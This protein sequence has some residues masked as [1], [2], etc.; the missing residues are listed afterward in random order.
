MVLEYES[1]HLPQKSPSFGGFYIPAP[2][3]AYGSPKMTSIR[4]PA[5]N[6]HPMLNRRRRCDVNLW[7]VNRG[8]T[9]RAMGQDFTKIM[10]NKL[11]RT[12][13]IMDLQ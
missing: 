13:I 3:F 2:W 12:W 7:S 11:Q 5:L 1:Q 4:S 8:F 6:L 9:D 10:G